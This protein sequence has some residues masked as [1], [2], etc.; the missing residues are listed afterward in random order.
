[1]FG[2]LKF[3]FDFLGSKIFVRSKCRCWNFIDK[4]LICMLYFIEVIF[5]IYDLNVYN[6]EFVFYR[7]MSELK[8]DL[9]RMMKE[10]L[11]GVFFLV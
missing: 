10:K 7:Y 2:M 4:I 1:M 3:F 5:C 9:V 11:R 6:E 8:V